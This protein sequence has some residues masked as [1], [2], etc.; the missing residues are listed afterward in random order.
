MSSEHG[1]LAVNPVVMPCYA[2]L[3]AFF[4][5]I[6]MEHPTKGNHGGMRQDQMFILSKKRC[7]GQAVQNAVADSITTAFAFNTFTIKCR[8]Y[9][10]VSAT[11]I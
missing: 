9:R 2:L 6:K 3:D 4:K 5:N 7:T 10:I 11:L 8:A 1:L